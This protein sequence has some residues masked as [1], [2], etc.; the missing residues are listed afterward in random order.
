M[1]NR[2]RRNIEDVAWNTLKA[3]GLDEPP[4]TIERVLEERRRLNSGGIPLSIIPID[5][6]TRRVPEANGHIE[7]LEIQFDQIVNV[8]G[9]KEQLDWYVL[10]EV[11]RRLP[12]T[13]SK[14]FHITVI[15]NN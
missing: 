1:N 10:P 15:K 8:E 7:Y 4:V 5:S 3:A 2:I 6:T 14:L 12:T 13:P 9:I 11:L